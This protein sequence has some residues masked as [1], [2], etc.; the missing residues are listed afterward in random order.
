MK[1]ILGFASKLE[2]PDCENGMQ[3]KAYPNSVIF[4]AKTFRISNFAQNKEKW[5]QKFIDQLISY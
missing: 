5:I 4:R 1:T 3:M 2:F